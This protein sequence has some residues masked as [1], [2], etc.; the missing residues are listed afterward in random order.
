M[1]GP[2]RV[3][4]DF[5]YEVGYGKPPVKNQFKRGQSGNPRGRPK[6][7]QR[8][9]ADMIND[10]MQRIVEIKGGERIRSD[11]LVIRDLV[12]D[13]AQGKRPAVLLLFDLIEWSEHSERAADNKQFDYANFLKPALEVWAAEA[14]AAEKEH[15]LW[16]AKR[17]SERQGKEIPPRAAAPPADPPSDR[18]DMG[19]VPVRRR[20][21]FVTADQSHDD[22]ANRPSDEEDMAARRQPTW[23]DV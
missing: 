9:L 17:R 10:Q 14:Q 21:E 15:E 8:G 22:V 2:M 1:N 13:A 3:P 4:R 23:P 12:R 6:K 7:C 16:L 5:T 19:R 18:A 20:I 11:R